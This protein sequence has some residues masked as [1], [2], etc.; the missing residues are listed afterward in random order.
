VDIWIAA[1]LPPE[2]VKVPDLRGSSQ[3]E[4]T[5]SIQN[6]KLRIGPFAERESSEPRGTVV[7]QDPPAGTEVDAGSLV[8]V[9]LA[10]PIPPTPITVVTVPSVVTLSLDSANSTLTAAGLQRGSVVE[11]PSAAT[12]GTVTFQSVDAGL[13]VAQGTAVN[14]V[15]ATPLVPWWSLIPP[16]LGSGALFA[17]ALAATATVKRVRRNRI[18]STPTLAPHFDAG[19]QFSVPG[20]RDLTN[21]EMALEAQRDRGVQTLDCP[22]EFIAGYWSGKQ[23]PSW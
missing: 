5:A 22:E 1:P 4:A 2:T 9:W 7:A 12:A 13:Q 23:E 6:L 3:N 20:D 8:S 18:M 19:T 10:V 17:L 21:F 15:V 14:L 16:W 11:R